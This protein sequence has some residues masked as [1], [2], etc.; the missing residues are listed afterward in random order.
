[1]RTFRHAG[2]AGLGLA[3]LLAVAAGC[4]P[5]RAASQAD[6]LMD[7]FRIQ[8]QEEGLSRLETDGRR[9]FAHYCVTCHGERGEGDGQNASSLDPPP[10]DF[11]SSLNAHR[12][13]YWKQ[14]I[15]AGSLAVGRSPLC[16]P[17]GRV[18]AADDIAAL[19]GYLEVLARPAGQTPLDPASKTPAPR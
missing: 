8:A 12:P 15:E 4:G 14:I 9:L 19:V 5:G 10:P 6:P 1:M 7:V 13:A 17:W 3:G 18:L 2:T 11:R 16:P